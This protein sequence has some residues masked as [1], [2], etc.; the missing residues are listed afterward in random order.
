MHRTLPVASLEAL[1]R[2]GV[3]L[4]YIVRHVI[5]EVRK[6][7]LVKGGVRGR[8][9]GLKGRIIHPGRTSISIVA[10]VGLLAKGSWPAVAQAQRR[11]RA[12]EPQLSERG[13]AGAFRSGRGT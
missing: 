12:V 5:R 3:G 2:L 10:W 8:G 4:Y 6:A 9:D 11:P 7:P 1:S 13:R